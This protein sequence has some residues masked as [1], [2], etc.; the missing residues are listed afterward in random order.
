MDAWVPLFRGSLSE[1]LVVRCRLEAEGFPVLV[2]DE[3]MK[4]VDPFITGMQPLL[5]EL[6]VR[7][8]DAAEARTCLAACLGSGAEGRP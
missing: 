5:V 4:V 8:E 2:R 3:V 6:M 1:V 7:R